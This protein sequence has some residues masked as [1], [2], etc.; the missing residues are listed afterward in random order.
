[1]FNR[2]LNDGKSKLKPR[3]LRNQLQILL[4]CSTLGRCKKKTY[5]IQTFSKL[6][7]T[8]KKT[9]T[10][11]ILIHQHLPKIITANGQSFPKLW[12][13]TLNTSRIVWNTFSILSRL[14]LLDNLWGWKNPC[15]STKKTPLNQTLKSTCKC[16]RKN[17]RNSWQL[18]NP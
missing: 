2:F 10:I 14:T 6:H 1:M 11:P 7:I 15:L 8:P 5:K 12:I 17:I 3:L 4:K 9:Q 13:K 16:T 18:N